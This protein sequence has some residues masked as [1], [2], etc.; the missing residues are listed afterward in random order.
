[1]KIL[2]IN[3]VVN[4]GSTGRIVEGIGDAI[5]N[6]GGESYI[7]YGRKKSLSKSRLIKIGNPIDVG[8]H[9]IKTRLFDAHG[10]GS[11]NATSK[12]IRK[13]DRIKPDIIHLH[14]LHGYYINIKKLFDYLKTTHIPIV[15]TLHDCWPFTGHCAHFDFVKCDKWKAECYKCPQI[16]TYPASIII[17]RS[18]KNFN[19]KKQ[20]FES[21]D[22]L[23]LVA[24]SK[25]IMNLVQESFLNRYKTKLIYNGVDIN[26]FK[27]STYAEDI[28]KK[29]HIEGK[30]IILGVANIWSHRKGLQ[31][32]IKLSRILNRDD[33]IFLVGLSKKQISNL[34]KNIIG[35]ERTENI[36]ELAQL[37]SS[38]EVFI[39]PTWEDNFPTTNIEALAC[40]TPIITYNTGGSIEAV[41][42][43]T[44]FIVEKGDI[45]GLK[46]CY[47][48]I[49]QKGKKEYSNACRDRA[50]KLF[51]KNDK[52]NEYIK[53]YNS[54]I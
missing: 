46:K 25:W 35:I 42:N 10:F 8:L 30:R 50:T 32:F 2:Q 20:Y 5:L 43:K 33:I 28:Y 13:I 6:S 29:Y 34:P 4:Y 44:G 1:M 18:K 49:I 16:N 47:L 41:D 45:E 23:T 7:A 19:I 15:W 54:L 27:P 3:S 51:N 11:Q 31:D 36:K 22:N 39:N 9:V 37:Y 52:Y 17:D 38:A 12:F 53:L 21:I 40:G 14:N 48:E 24:V 26:I